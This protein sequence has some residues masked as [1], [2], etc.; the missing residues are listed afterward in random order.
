LWYS[1][2]KTSSRILRDT[3]RHKMTMGNARFVPTNIGGGN[4]RFFLPIYV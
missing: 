4:T 2:D 3:T 1:A